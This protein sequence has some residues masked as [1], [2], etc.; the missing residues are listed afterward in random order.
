MSKQKPAHKKSLWTKIIEDWASRAH[1][2][3]VPFSMMI[4]E[5]GKTDLLI[6]I[7]RLFLTPALFY[8][9]LAVLL[10][11]PILS[12]KEYLRASKKRTL[13]SARELNQ[14][15]HP[16]LLAAD[17][18]CSKPAQRRTPSQDLLSPNKPSHSTKKDLASSKR[19]PK[20]I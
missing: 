8:A 19:N 4:A 14:P 18:K 7:G 13:P 2:W 10:L 6:T 20:M 11:S 3:M 16:E 15:E 1:Q 9:G 12:I 17:L 5:I